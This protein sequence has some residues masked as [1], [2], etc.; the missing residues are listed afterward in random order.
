M[1]CRTRRKTFIWTTF[2]NV[3]S[4]LFIQYSLKSDKGCTVSFCE[5]TNTCSVLKTNINMPVLY[6]F[7]WELWPASQFPQN[8]SNN[9]ATC[10][11]KPIRTINVVLLK[12]Y[13]YNQF[14]HGVICFVCLCISTAGLD[15]GP[16]T[17]SSTVVPPSQAGRRTPRSLPEE[18]LDGILSPELDKMVTDG[19]C[20]NPYIQTHAIY[21]E[22]KITL[23]F[24]QF[25]HFRINTQQTT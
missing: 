22:R 18:P 10:T 24:L 16:L 6:T 20:G 1:G 3:I 7:D 4:T 2:W 21:N 12:A 9:T 25:L 14:L 23:W 8:Y 15:I 11:P 13:I 17:D 19:Q 5:E